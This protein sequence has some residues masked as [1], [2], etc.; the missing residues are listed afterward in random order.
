[1][2]SLPGLSLDVYVVGRVR[3]DNIQRWASRL[4]L[5][6]ALVNQGRLT[7]NHDDNTLNRLTRDPTLTVP[8]LIRARGE[9]YE[10]L[11]NDSLVLTRWSAQQ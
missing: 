8:V 3:D 9:A 7:L 11:P 5:S 6:E 2:Q 4:K 10:M 1:V